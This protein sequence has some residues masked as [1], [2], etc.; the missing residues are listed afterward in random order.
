VLWEPGADAPK[1][2]FLVP[3]W[4]AAGELPAFVAAYRNL[5]YPN[6]ELVLCAGGPDG[7]FEVARTHVSPDIVVLEQEPEEGK[8][9]ALRKSYPRAS[10]SIVYLTDIDCRPNDA[11]VNNLVWHLALGQAQVVTGSP[12]PVNDQVQNAFVRTQWAVEQ[13]TQPHLVRE[14]GGIRGCNAALMRAAVEASGAFSTDAPSGTDYTLAKETQRAGYHILFA[15]GHPMPTIYPHTFGLYVRKQ[16]RWIRNVYVIGKQF[17][18]AAEVRATLPTLALPYVLI[19]GIVAR[20]RGSFLAKL[21]LLLAV[22]AVLNR[23]WYQRQVGL[24]PRI[25]ASIQH[26]AATQ[27][28]AMRAGFDIV[29]KNAAW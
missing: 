5:T 8:Q 18:A 28:A 6:R 26:F 11:T 1:I 27:V 20:G 10:G 13:A 24:Q 12:R 14:V 23:L 3:A 25:M 22:H 17:N 4:N 2:S 15:P 21:S 19:A 7:S 29:R 16:A 9:S